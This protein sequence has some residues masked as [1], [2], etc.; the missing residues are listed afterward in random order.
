MAR[1]AA[2]APLRRPAF[3]RLW[4]GL[5]I[6]YLGDQF[7]TIALLWFVLQLTGS[8]ASVGLVI[9]CFDL[10]GVVTGAILGRLLD[11]YQPRLAMGFDNLVRA[12]LIAVIP[13]L[14]ALGRLQFWHV[15]V[16]ALLAGALSPA[17]TAGVRAFVPHLVDDAALDR[18]NALTAAS[19]QFSYLAGPVAAGFAVARFGGP[20]ALF[21]DAASFLLMGL[22]ALT[23]PTISREPR[24]AQPAPANRRLAG[25]LLARKG[26]WAHK[27]LEITARAPFC[28]LLIEAFGALFSLPSVSALTLLSLVFFFS[29]GPLEAALPVYSSQTLHANAGGYGMLWTGFGVGAFA[30]VLTLTKLSHRWRP[31]I[32]LPMIA[33]L[34]G[35][36]LCPL[37]FI[38]QLPLAM[39]FLGVAG[40][41]WAPY[42]PMETTLL[43]RLV[44]AGIRGQVFGARHSLVVAATPLGAAFGGVL[45]QYLSAPV[46]IAISGVACVLAGLGGLV[47]PS[48]RRL[49]RGIIP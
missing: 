26:G 15:F 29:Y 10:P 43:Q 36:L 7:T 6:S 9:L 5:T 47:S 49:Q 19:L 39:L 11:R 17:T 30:G 16:L 25:P 44:P 33:V 38:R 27:I 35:T 37:F 12:A 22:L 32:A 4:L 21:I 18:A 34:W 3:Q 31:G 48:L 1:T 23:L 40:A 13:T 2:V 46:V 20:W 28:G 14:Y 24:V 8:G 42:T 41:S 45:L